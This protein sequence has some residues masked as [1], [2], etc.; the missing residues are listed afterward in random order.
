MI[1]TAIKPLD[2]KRILRSQMMSA[3]PRDPFARNEGRALLFVSDRSVVFGEPVQL[4]HYTDQ[5]ARAK[6]PQGRL[7]H[8]LALGS[9]PHTVVAGGHLPASV[10]RTM[11]PAGDPIMTLAGPLFLTD[12]AMALDVGKTLE[13]TLS[14][15]A[16]TDASASLAMQAVKS[17]ATLAEMGLD[18]PQKSG[19]N[20]G[21]HKALSKALASAA[22]AGRRPPPTRTDTA[23]DAA[24]ADAAATADPRKPGVIEQQEL[25]GPATLDDL[26]KEVKRIAR[27]IETAEKEQTTDIDLALL[28]TQ[29]L[30]AQEAVKTPVAEHVRQASV[31]ATTTT[32][33][34]LPSSPVSDQE[35]NTVLVDEIT[36]VTPAMCAFL[37]SRAK[38][39]FLLAGDPRQL[40]PV[41]ESGDGE[42]PDDYE[43]MGRDI[44]D[45]SGVSSGRGEERLI[46]P[47]DTM[48]ER[49]DAKADG[50]HD[51]L[52]KVVQ[53]R[54]N[55][56]REATGL[57]QE[58]LRRQLTLIKARRDAALNMR[59]DGKI[60]EADFDRKQ[61]E[62]DE[63]ETRF[64]LLLEE[65]TAKKAETR[66][67]SQEAT[68]TFAA[69]RS[70]WPTATPVVKRRILEIVFQKFTLQGKTLVVRKRTPIELFLAG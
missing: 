15:K 21:L 52:A 32:L 59:L 60:K 33:A 49:A 54:I 11:L 25:L 1:V 26:N 57:R 5:L 44:F 47:D 61:Q 22:Y 40:G 8:A 63:D 41:Y 20:P 62:Y 66:Q 36:M 50:F 48:P 43:W 68:R 34:Y 29:L 58:E 16:P 7:G 4:A 53:A 9:N 64:R 39:R 56:S 46:K 27:L 38:Q 3:Q 42:T 69:L 70:L 13:L 2:R 45:K 65:C 12:A 24:R 18:G 51:W 6:A 10:R 35:W 55:D 23:D 17:F 31:V 67:V 28:R 30:A 14:L 37:A 19:L